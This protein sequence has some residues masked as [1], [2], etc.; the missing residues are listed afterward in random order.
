MASV[1][2]KLFPARGG[3]L[4]IHLQNFRDRLA[5]EGK[6]LGWEAAAIKAAQGRCDRILGA[7]A[8]SEQRLADYKA[9][10]SATKAVKQTELTALRSEVRRIKASAKFSEEI[11]RSLGIVSATAPQTIVGNTKAV[12][13]AE[14]RKGSV[15]I[16]WK[17]GALDGVN[18]YMRRQGDSE[19]RLLGRDNVSP[20]DD[21]QPLA[22]PGVPEV[23]EYHVHGVVRDQ[24][25]GAPSD[26]C[27]VLFAG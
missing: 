22:Q 9:Q 23:R 10:I 20:Y 19:W 6:T 13:K 1:S 17:K 2:S 11:G 4:A 7:L 14:V 16:R 27:S 25:V 18:V 3:D 15:R 26:L 24:E 8:L 12:A 21:T 5:S